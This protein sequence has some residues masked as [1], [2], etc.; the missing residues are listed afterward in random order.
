MMF[1]HLQSKDSGYLDQVQLTGML[2]SCV[3]GIY[4]NERNR[5]QPVTIDLCLYLNTRKA[6]ASTSI[7]DTIDYASAVKEVTFIL[8]QCEF[9]LIETAVEA[10][11]R[12]FIATYIHENGLP[13]VDA[14]CVRI[15]KPSALTHGV[16]PCIQTLRQRDTGQ[17]ELSLEQPKEFV[18]HESEMGKLT[19]NR[20]GPNESLQIEV[21]AGKL[22]SL[23]P[24]GRAQLDGR[25]IPALQAV[26]ANPQVGV[27]THN[28]PTDLMVIAYLSGK[29]PVIRSF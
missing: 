9:L 15:S 26:H 27:I 10:V 28:Q 5:K 3:I 12:Y 1:P 29:N 21:E 25:P 16:I 7:H 22:N 19:L 4:P 14:V 24:L 6:A 20:I 23:L 11:C 18:I 2:L 17:T 13:Q 8:E